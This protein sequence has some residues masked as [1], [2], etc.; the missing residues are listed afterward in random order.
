MIQ[1]DQEIL[2]R[3]RLELRDRQATVLVQQRARQET[4]KTDNAL[5]AELMADLPTESIRFMKN[6]DFANSFSWEEVEPFSSFRHR[7]KDARHEFLDEVIEGKKHSLVERTS[8]LV[9]AIALNTGIQWHGRHAVA[10]ASKLDTPHGY[11]EH[12]KEIKELNDRADAFV[13]AHEDF[14]RTARRRLAT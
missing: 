3:L 9:D 10:E 14:I 7:W 1:A 4:G 11:R 8:E 6:F 2:E 12:A 5:L 13:E